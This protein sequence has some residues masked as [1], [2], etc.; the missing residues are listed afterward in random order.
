MRAMIS[1]Y[2]RSGERWPSRHG[3][4]GTRE[5]RV[6]ESSAV[7]DGGIDGPYFV[8]ERRAQ[9]DGFVECTSDRGI[10]LNAYGGACERRD[11][12]SLGTRFANVTDGREWPALRLSHRQEQGAVAHRARNAMIADQSREI[13]PSGNGQRGTSATRFEAK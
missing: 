1:S 13:C 3:S 12:K 5:K 4:S 6:A 11:P 10:G 9:C 7:C 2:P 8:A